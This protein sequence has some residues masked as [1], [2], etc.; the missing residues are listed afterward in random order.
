[1]R[2]EIEMQNIQNNRFVRRDR[3][4]EKRKTIRQM[5]FTLIV[6]NESLCA[7][8]GEFNCDGSFECE[9]F[10]VDEIWMRRL[11]TKT[12]PTCN[13]TTRVLMC[14]CTDH[15]GGPAYTGKKSKTHTQVTNVSIQ[16]QMIFGLG[17]HLLDAE[18]KLFTLDRKEYVVCAPCAHVLCE[19]FA[20]CLWLPRFL[21]PR[22]HH[23]H[24]HRRLSASRRPKTGKMS[25]CML[26]C[27]CVFALPPAKSEDAVNRNQTERE[28]A[29][30]KKKATKR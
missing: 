8:W 1:M 20:F 26:V 9:I 19:L 3:S 21:I 5:A 13:P 11:N 7:V 29:I 14:S 15:T 18:H 6:L 22:R 12:F 2:F 17:N 30:A 27:G 28:I 24:R 25:V 4:S 23:R 16:F 10:M